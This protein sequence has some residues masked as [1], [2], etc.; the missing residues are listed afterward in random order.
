MAIGA[1]IITAVAAAASAA[2]ARKQRKEAVKEA[3]R[4]ERRAE[5][6]LD[7]QASLAA[8]EKA[9][10]DKKLQTARQRVLTGQ[11]G[12]T[13]LLFGTEKGVQ[14]ADTAQPKQNTLGV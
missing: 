8:E 12:R 5:E 2:N 11:G 4:T 3:G 13:S 7:K 14:D 6:A 10:A 9:A 1:A